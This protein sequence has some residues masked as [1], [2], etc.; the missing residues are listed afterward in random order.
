M[1]TT[2]VGSILNYYVGKLMK[3]TIGVFLINLKERL[4]PDK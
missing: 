2:G 1:V 3:L 4:S